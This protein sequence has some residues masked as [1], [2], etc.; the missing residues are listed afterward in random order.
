M[1][2]LLITLFSVKSLF[3]FSIDDFENISP[4]IRENHSS[5]ALTLNSVPG[6]EGNGLELDYDLGAGSV[7]WVQ[8][9]KDFFLDITGYDAFRFSWEGSGAENL[10]EFK[11]TD[12][13][14]DVF[15]LQNFAS[16]AQTDWQT[17]ALS[18]RNGSYPMKHL[19]GT[20]D[21]LL[22]MQK[23]ARFSFTIV[24]DEGGS[25]TLELDRFALVKNPSLVLDDYNDGS[26]PNTLNGTWGPVMPNPGLTIVSASYSTHTYE[27]TFSLKIIHDTLGTWGGFYNF[28]S[29]STAVPRDLS[30]YSALSLAVEG[31][32]SVKIELKDSQNTASYILS[33]SGDFSSYTVPLSNFS[34]LGLADC[35]ELNFIWEN[36]AG[37]V[38]LDKI[39]F[40]HSLQEEILD[41]DEFRYL[42]E[43]S[44][45]T[46]YQQDPDDPVYISPVPGLSGDAY[47]LNYGLNGGAWIALEKNQGINFSTFTRLSFMY[48]GTGDA[49]N[50]EVKL[51]DSNVVFIKKIYA[52]SDTSDSWRKISIPVD[53]FELFISSGTDESLDFSAVRR[54]WLALSSHGGGG[55][56]GKASFDNLLL[57]T[58]A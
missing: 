40:L 49:N 24:R 32:G 53:E 19:F 36:S 56:G 29:S 7:T 48:K 3:S 45:W 44:G 20:G 39:E 4:W 1:I 5:A 8:T 46:L 58:P 25:G 57:E 43:L 42:P 21:G 18:F 12:I 16:T 10:L 31:S 34:G 11:I 27:G 35:R 52:V 28:L 26:A 37:I 33:Y 6:F 14:G 47:R 15:G 38:Y 30:P 50:L 22:N 2:L 51:G 13:D 17:A 55:G 23:I 54:I 9:A 41:L